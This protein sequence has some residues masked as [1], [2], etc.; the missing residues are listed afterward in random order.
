[1]IAKVDQALFRRIGRYAYEHFE[2][3]RASYHVSASLE[4][5]PNL[6]RM[7]DEQLPELLEQDD[8][9]QVL[10][11]TFGSVLDTYRSEIMTVLCNHEETHYE[12]LARHF[13]RHLE[14]FA[15]VTV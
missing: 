10:H 14:P 15:E 3:D 13:E 8:A 6:D 7:P 12:G 4:R 9:R 11:V 2:E 1:M 5:V